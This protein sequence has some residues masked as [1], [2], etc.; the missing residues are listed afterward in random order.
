ML[1]YPTSKAR[2]LLR[3]CLTITFFL[4]LHTIGYAQQEE[5]SLKEV[6]SEFS[7]KNLLDVRI[8]TVSKKEETVFDA[9]LSS[10]V[11]TGEEIKNSGST[12][13]M[14]AL[15]L[16]PGLI[17]REETPGNYD[18]HIRGYDGVDPYVLGVQKINTT[19]LVMINNRIVYS[20]VFGGTLW[21]VLQV[22]IDDVEKIEVV[23]GPSSALYG[24]NAATG[25]INIITKK[26]F[27][28]K[29]VH[30]SSY[31]QAGMYNTRLSSS[32]LSYCNK[33][34]SLSFRLSGNLDQRER[35]KTEYYVLPDVFGAVIND[36]N[37]FKGGYRPAPDYDSPYR[38]NTNS[39]D[40]YPDLDVATDRYS[41]QGH[42]TWKTSN[43][44]VN[45]LGGF[46]RSEI[47]RVYFI[48]NFYPITTEKNE[49]EFGQIFGT[50]KNLSFNTDY[51]NNRNNTIGAFDFNFRMFNAN[52]DYNIPLS[53][54]L[55]LKPGL[56]FHW[57]DFISN[58]STLI[59]SDE[60][61]TK[62]DLTALN[63]TDGN[64][65]HEV[66]MTSSV[67]ARLEYYVGK[68]RFVGGGRVDKFVHPDKY[69]FSPQVLATYKPSNDVLLRA[70]YGR[71][72]RAP[73]AA[74][75]FTKFRLDPPHILA[76]LI[77]N[78][79]Q[80]SE[81]LT[82]DMV[83][84]GARV[85]LNDILSADLEIFYSKASNFEQVFSGTE[86]GVP[87]FMYE[88]SPMKASQIG[89]TLTLT[90]VPTPKLRLV[91]FVTVQKTSV[92]N[93]D[94]TPSPTTSTLASASTTPQYDS[95][96]TSKATPTIFGG[97]AVN[98]APAPKWNI[99][100]NT[101]FYG[102]QTI[103]LTGEATA[104]DKV[105]SNFILNAATSYEV[106]PGLKVFVNGRN[107]IGGDKRQYAFTDKIKPMVLGGVV[108]SF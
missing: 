10:T 99:N 58:Q 87:Y 14:E 101:Y 44:E 11:L 1:F 34:E 47:Q 104:M 65:S 26:P 4:S 76:F 103:L 23:R 19:T 59:F 77:S 107:L 71:S 63:G 95:S 31:T 41:L 102:E 20:D 9:P 60:L 25:V 49:S 46:S 97:F 79:E 98:Y 33:D 53:E 51:S 3:I 27:K 16:V 40:L 100:V 62:A 43:S 83:E 56:A 54:G 81:L 57:V 18:I 29:G 91:G 37:Y 82:I 21:D 89:A 84:T 72:S 32:S 42:G 70:S 80:P 61:F 38:P 48:N 24:P 93:Y 64:G 69:L 5:T 55:S 36:P 7:L 66:N 45:V 90:A 39:K 6:F 88:I 30:V 85:K 74:N 73:F 94:F 78:T 13:I 28:E 8:V 22:G 2:Q 67:Y 92:S 105:S 17:V 96:F 68:F 86:S 15:R 50:W 106:I 75:L 52:V 108:A 12:S 35:H